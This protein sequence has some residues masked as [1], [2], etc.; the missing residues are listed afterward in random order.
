[1]NNNLLLTGDPQVGKTTIIKKALQEIHTKQIK[2]GGFYTNEIR[3]N[4][5]RVG[6]EV[7]TILSNKKDVLAHVNF[8]SSFKVGKYGVNKNAF[9]KVIIDEFNLCS[10][11]KVDLIIIDEIGKM[12]MISDF[13]CEKVI[14]ILNGSIPVLGVIKKK[15]NSTFLDN[16]H[17]IFTVNIVEINKFN[18]EIIYLKTIEWLNKT[19][20]LF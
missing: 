9:E 1:M 4:K 14:E 3:E 10:N 12:E 20:N 15:G 18:R 5:T 7:K 16:V 6:F 13:F 19:L 2:I 11:E 8:N 17:D